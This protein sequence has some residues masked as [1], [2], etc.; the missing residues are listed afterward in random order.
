M[1]AQL[2]NFHFLRPQALWLLIPA[3]LLLWLVRRRDDPRVQLRGVI[4]PHLLEHLLIDPQRR[5]RIR[6]VH[7]VSLSLA[8]AALGLAGPTWRQEPTPFTE[9]TAPLAV[10]IDL[11]ADMDAID[12]QP[13]RL[14]RAKL[15]VQDLLK[16]RPGAR[17]ALVVYTAKAYRVLP[18]TD[19]PEL[20]DLFLSSLATRLMP[21]AG[22]NSASALQ[23][24]EETLAKTTTPGTILFIA[25]G[26]ER[27][28]FPDFARAKETRNQALFLAVGTS[29][30]GPL[31]A[32]ENRYQTNATGGRIISRL[33]TAS[34]KALESDTGVPVSRLTLDDA[35][36]DWIEKRIQ[37]HLVAARDKDPHARWEDFGYF[38][39]FP[40]ALLAVLWF[41][42]GW[43][44][45]WLPALVI[46]MLAPD[47]KAGD[48]QFIDLWMTHDQQARYAFEKGDY[49]SAARL[50]EDPLWKG[51]SFYRAGKYDEAVS[52]L[53]QVE[54]AEGY[55]WL[56]NVFARSKKLPE[57]VQSYDQAL[58]LRTNFPEAEANKALVLS[59]IPKQKKD[60]NEG[61]E[62][63]DMKPDEIKFDNKGKKGKD[64]NIRRLP[65]TPQDMAEIWM[66]QIQVTPADFLRMKFS[67]QNARP[68]RQG[69]PP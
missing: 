6:P 27:S 25:S 15:K 1:G 43:T 62:A 29:K 21:S 8:I 16:S 50:F 44:I 41:R 53:A 11:S 67:I 19:D 52:A 59:L 32:G 10:A 40:T 33:D 26:I 20:V 14:E 46:L 48:F 56:G 58:R 45:R 12:I 7:L 38:L 17:T 57:A 4:A 34:F 37:S 18:L 36:L 3:A 28:A 2:A 13:T 35:D 22:R 69:T 60:P 51:I 9:D 63:P 24:S 5:L 31:L 54:S 55:F 61:E 66:R 65:K 42:K 68:P 64:I 30:G 47:T 39:V 49:A 23:L